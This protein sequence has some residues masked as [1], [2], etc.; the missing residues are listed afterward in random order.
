M[1]NKKGAN[2]NMAVLE[3]LQ[4][5]RHNKIIH[6][7]AITNINIFLINNY[8]SHFFIKKSGLGFSGLHLII[9][10]PR[11]VISLCSP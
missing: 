2:N 10:E 7:K 9:N 6:K 8:K 11:G 1:I 3:S 4:I 5:K